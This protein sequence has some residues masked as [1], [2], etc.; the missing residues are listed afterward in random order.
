MLIN[1]G[2]VEHNMERGSEEEVSASLPIL[3]CTLP[4]VIAFIIHVNADSHDFDHSP[5]DV[6]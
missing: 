4:S 2:F 1:N 6:T 5:L 3:K